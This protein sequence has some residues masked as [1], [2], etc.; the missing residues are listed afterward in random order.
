MKLRHGFVSPAIAVPS[1]PTFALALQSRVLPAACAVGD[2][3][4]HGFSGYG[5]AVR[6]VLHSVPHRRLPA[7]KRTATMP[8][9]VGSTGQ[10]Q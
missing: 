2:K 7:V 8:D 1:A 10:T 4:A 3:A 5:G 9:R 6:D